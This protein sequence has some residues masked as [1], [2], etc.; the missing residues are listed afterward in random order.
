MLKQFVLG[1][2]FCTALI[3]AAHAQSKDLQFGIKGGL[4]FSEISGSTVDKSLRMGIQFGGVMTQKL[5]DSLSMQYEAL[6]SQK[7]IVE[8]TTLD[9][10][11]YKAETNIDYLEIPVFAK[12]KVAEK[13]AVY[14]GGYVGWALSKKGKLTGGSISAEVDLDEFVNDLDYGVLLGVQA[15]LAEHWAVDARYTL[16]LTDVIT[17]T[18]TD[19][20]NSTIAISATYLL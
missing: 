5:S 6:Y 12:F 8:T 7:G 10:V 9:S 14:G 15:Q 17:S 1:M 19:G 3:G 4:G 20:K 11:D 18:S 16:G 13:W 2:V